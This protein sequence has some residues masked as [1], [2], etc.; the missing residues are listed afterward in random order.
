MRPAQQGAR[1]LTLRAEQGTIPRKEDDSLAEW[2]VE[3][4][5][6]AHMDRQHTYVQGYSRHALSAT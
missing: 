1:L 4:T 5:S 6:S 3:I 2:I